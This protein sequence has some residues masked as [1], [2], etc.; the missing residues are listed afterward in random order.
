MFWKVLTSFG[1][2]LV[3]VSC[4]VRRGTFR[5]VRPGTFRQV[6]PGTFRQV[7]RGTFRL[8]WGRFYKPDIFSSFD[9]AVH[10]HN[11]PFLLLMAAGKGEVSMKLEQR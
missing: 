10:T 4:Q 11:T 9:P 5:Q 7:R 6:R 1:S 8:V 3:L 2:D